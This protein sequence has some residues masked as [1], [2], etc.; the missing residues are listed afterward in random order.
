MTDTPQRT[1]LHH[2]TGPG[3]FTPDGCSVELYT[4][5]LANGEPEIVAGAVPPGAT[6]LELGAG[7]GRMTRPLLAHGLRVT[8]VDESPEMLARIDGA[9]AVCAAIED[10][11]LDTRFDVVLL[12]SFLVNTADETLRGALLRTCARHTAPGGC[13]LV[14]REGQWQRDLAPGTEWHRDGLTVRVALREPAA[15]GARRTRLEYAY[16]DAAWS[17][18][19]VSHHL[20]EPQFEEALAGAG[21]ALDRYLTEDRTWVRAVPA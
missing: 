19:F 13:V 20:T 1:L 9:P 4:R 14:Q 16:R 12:A 10:L 7:A 15:G 11:A 6:L 18:T 21:L 8:A 2:G 3:A 5:L 17:Q